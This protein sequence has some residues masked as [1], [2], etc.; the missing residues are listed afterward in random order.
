LRGGTILEKLFGKKLKEGLFNDE[1]MPTTGAGKED[2]TIDSLR[3]T[4]SSPTD[5]Q[6][7]LERSNAKQR[8]ENR[9]SLEHERGLLEVEASATGDAGN[10]VPPSDGGRLTRSSSVGARHAGNPATP[11]PSTPELNLLAD[12][13]PGTGR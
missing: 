6:D 9:T 4:I 12:W 13:I 2:E 1:G 10:R 3:P 8:M 7:L 5:F 11:A